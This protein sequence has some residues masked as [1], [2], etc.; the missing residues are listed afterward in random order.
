[1]AE[2]LA[3]AWLLDVDA[4]ARDLG[5]RAALGIAEGTRLTAEWYRREGWL[6]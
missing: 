6:A 1:M 3:P 4:A 2:F 5:W